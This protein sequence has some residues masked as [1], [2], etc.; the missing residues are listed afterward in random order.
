KA[1]PT[2]LEQR[3][4]SWVKGLKLISS[5]LGKDMFLPRPESLLASGPGAEPF[6]WALWLA[7]W[8]EAFFSVNQL[9]VFLCISFVLFTVIAV[10]CCYH[11]Y[12]CFSDCSITL[13]Y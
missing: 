11:C 6:Y 1:W 4:E 5:F 12:N 9:A 2:G 8:R 13:L 7:W 10:Y 3:G